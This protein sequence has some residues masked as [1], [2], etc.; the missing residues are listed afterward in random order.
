[1]LRITEN[2][3]EIIVRDIPVVRWSASF[4]ALF[5]LFL[6]V[7]LGSSFDSF[8]EI[9]RGLLWT[10]SFTMY[11]FSMF[12]NPATTTKI[13]KK[14]RLVSV[15][16]RSLF[17]YSF[18]VYTFDELRD[19]IFVDTAG[20]NN[21][22]KLRLMLP[23]KSEQNIELSASVR[24]YKKPLRNVAKLLNGYLTDSSGKIASKPAVLIKDICDG[25]G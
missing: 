19:L 5:A 2:K 13:D 23:L 12:S 22:R 15:R 10:L 17:T 7:F 14:N 9:A 16:K 1:M 6:M 18:D 25:N 20:F 24:F 11:I 4:I 3:D 21:F 8:Y